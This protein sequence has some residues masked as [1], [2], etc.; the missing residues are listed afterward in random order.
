M[1]QNTIYTDSKN[2]WDDWQAINKTNK[3]RDKIKDND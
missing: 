1:L 2:I 3:N